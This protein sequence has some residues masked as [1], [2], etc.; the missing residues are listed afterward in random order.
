M[1]WDRNPPQWLWRTADP[2]L[3]LVALLMGSLALVVGSFVAATLKKALSAY[4]GGALAVGL[5]LSAYI[6]LTSK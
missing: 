5:V 2:I 1:Y 4:E 3:G 6:L